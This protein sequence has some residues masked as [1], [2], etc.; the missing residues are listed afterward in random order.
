MCSYFHMISQNTQ[1]QWLRSTIPSRVRDKVHDQIRH[2]LQKRVVE[3]DNVTHYHMV[4]RVSGSFCEGKSHER[5]NTFPDFHIMVAASIKEPI[6]NFETLVFEIC[7]NHI[8]DDGMKF[9]R[10]C[11]RT[12]PHQM[13]AT[14]EE[15]IFMYDYSNFQQQNTN[16]SCAFQKTVPKCFHALLCD[17][18]EI[19]EWAIEVRKVLEKFISEQG[20]IRIILDMAI[21][22]NRIK[23]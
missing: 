9:N 11:P 2:Q 6:N 16:W 12:I 7:R 13:K 4:F 22:Q 3:C 21:E 17:C 19:F 8:T 5:I 14:L 1:A 23:K 15:A 10:P 18:K 20:V